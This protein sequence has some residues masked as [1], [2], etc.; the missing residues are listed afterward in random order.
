MWTNFVC[1]HYLHVVYTCIARLYIFCPDTIIA[2]FRGYFSQLKFFIIFY[3]SDILPDSLMA[4]V[5]AGL[6]SYM[7]VQL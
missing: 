7:I 6:F 4:V 2:I 3:L 5:P 1:L